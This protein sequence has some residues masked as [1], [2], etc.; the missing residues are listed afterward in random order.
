MQRHILLVLTLLALVPASGC[1]IGRD[2]VNQP[3]VHESVDKLQPGTTTAQQAVELLGAPTEVVQLGF[4]SA[5]RYEFATAK[6]AGLFLLVVFLSNTDTRSDRIWLFFD[7]KDVLT[8]VAT[9]FAA[10]DASYSMPWEEN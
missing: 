9:T 2:N 10:A 5:Y 7:D 4:R 3:L 8:H 1:M 6:R